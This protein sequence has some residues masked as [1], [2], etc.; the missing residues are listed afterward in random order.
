MDNSVNKSPAG[1]SEDIVLVAISLI[2]LLLMIL[3]WR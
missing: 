3:H 1:K 2:A